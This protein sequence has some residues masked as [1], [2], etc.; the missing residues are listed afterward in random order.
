MERIQKREARRPRLGAPDG[1]RLIAPQTLLCAPRGDQSI[2]LKNGR[3][4]PQARDF[5]RG[6][7]STMYQ[8]FLPRP[9]TLV[10]FVPCYLRSPL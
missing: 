3:D 4:C 9:I 2:E 8:V 6:A 5:S 10:E 7:A 1:N